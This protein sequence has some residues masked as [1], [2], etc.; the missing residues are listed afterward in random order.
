M[1]LAIAIS[2]KR[3][4][5]VWSILS[6]HKS[7]QVP[8]S[9]KVIPHSTD[10]GNMVLISILL[11]PTFSHE[12]GTSP[13][14]PLNVEL[15]CYVHLPPYSHLRVHKPCSSLDCA[16]VTQS[17]YVNHRWKSVSFPLTTVEILPR[18]NS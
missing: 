6:S 17:R 9:Q 2:N 3:S 18:E 13:D 10:E 16:K 5:Y 11:R 7:G 15:P 4:P 8:V 1:V 14:G 12:N